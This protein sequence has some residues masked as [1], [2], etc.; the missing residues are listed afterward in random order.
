MDKHLLFVYSAYFF[1]FF[2]LFIFGLNSFLSLKKSIQ[3]IYTFD[4]DTKN[5]NR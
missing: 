4:I 1:T 3:N 5:S 2:V